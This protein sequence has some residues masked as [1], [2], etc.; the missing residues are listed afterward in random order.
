MK[1]KIVIIGGGIGGLAAAA[2]LAKDG[3]KV[4][5]VEKNEQPGGRASL[6]KEQ[7]YRF[8]MGP[9]WFMMPD[10]YERFFQEFNL[11]LK[12]VLKLKRLQPHYRVFWED[13]KSI[14]MSGILERDKATFESL[15]TGAGRKLHEYLEVAKLKYELSMKHVLYENMD[16]IF[17][18]MKPEIAKYGAT[19]GVL[20]SMHNHIKK[21]FSHPKIQ[22]ILEYNLVF[23][24][25]S[26]QNAPSLFSLMSHVDMNLGVFYPRG[27]MYAIVNSLVDLGKQY[28]VEYFYH[29]SVQEIEIQ[30]G[31]VKH[32]HTS[33]KSFAADAVVSNADY[34]F[35]ESVLSDQSLRT[36]SE[37]YW[38]KKTFAPSAFLLYL[39]LNKQFPS[40][41]HHTLYF[42]DDWSA[43]FR[44]VFEHP[45]WP[46]APSVY[47]NVPSRTDKS[48]API[49]HE[50]IMILI[51]VAPGLEES[52]QWKE[53]YAQFVI[54]YLEKKLDLSLKKHIQYQK[55]FSV[56][57]FTQR[58]NSY[59]GNALGGIAHTFFQSAIW[60][61][62]NISKKIPNLFFVGANT[63]PG[64]GVPPA[65]I[66]SHLVQDRIHRYFQEV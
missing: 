32:V 57:D 34:A 10:V 23:L 48:V 21:Y 24:G 51:P 49:N 36:Y 8:D 16:S 53:A 60:R 46:Q 25:C 63:V 47:L 42:G 41:S 22:Q 61:P 38:K 2:L 65:I 7:G 45:R 15:E 33:S 59:A 9:S 50:N 43:H 64:I 26:P 39:G 27:G 62:N 40:L 20:E 58:Y 56:S 17:G 1:K 35:T 29:S 52:E 3:Y 18:L 14:E 4:T 37:K 11:E 13:G 19:L 44:D 31:K 12:D 66:S 28:G 5:V 54:A 30:T 55:I 6:L